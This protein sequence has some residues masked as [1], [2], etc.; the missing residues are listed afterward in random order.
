MVSFELLL[1][2]QMAGCLDRA[3]AE[4]VAAI[5]DDCLYEG[6][7]I[8]FTQGQPLESLYLLLEG[9]VDLCSSPCL[10]SVPSGD[11]AEVA[12]EPPS[13]IAMLRSRQFTTTAVAMTP[14]RVL[15]IDTRALAALCEKNAKLN[16]MW[17]PRVRPMV[18]ELRG[19]CHRMLLE[20]RPAQVARGA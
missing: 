3:E 1:E 19:E 7:S 16:Y 6:N 12:S 5:G 10:D 18:L 8:I 11:N 9:Q 20:R 2:Y 15:K 4:A 13:A 17:L 14:S